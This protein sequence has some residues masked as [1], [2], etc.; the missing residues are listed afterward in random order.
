MKM[1][2]EIGRFRD[3][4]LKVVVQ[5]EETSYFW[6]HSLTECIV[7]EDEK[8]RLETLL[9]VEHWNEEHHKEFELLWRQF[10]GSRA[11]KKKRKHEF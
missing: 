8:L 5:H 6:E 11:S 2:I 7:E 1:K 10:S 9:M 4:R 3:G